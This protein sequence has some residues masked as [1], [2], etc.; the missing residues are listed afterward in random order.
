[1]CPSVPRSKCIKPSTSSLL[2]QTT[3]EEMVNKGLVSTARSEECLDLEKKASLDGTLCVY[4]VFFADHGFSERYVYY[5]VF[6]GN[7]DSWC[8][9]GRTRVT[10]ETNTGQWHC[11][12]RQ[13]QTISRRI[14]RVLAMWR[15]FQEN[16]PILV[17]HQH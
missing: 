5:S 1:M 14:H 7:T 16:T 6:T 12:C 17:N 15:T 4:P 9:F 13:T 8:L 11:H 3:L 2:N 10:F